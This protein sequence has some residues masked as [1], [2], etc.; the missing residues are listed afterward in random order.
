VKRILSA[1]MALSL[2]ILSSGC[3]VE[4]RDEGYQM[5]RKEYREREEHRGDRYDRN[6]DERM[7]REEQRDYD[8]RR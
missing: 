2:L 8:D 4:H 7:R 1:I 5:H 6:Y 3:I